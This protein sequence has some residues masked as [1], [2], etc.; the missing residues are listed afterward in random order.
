MVS[1]DIEGEDSGRIVSAARSATARP[2]SG[3]VRKRQ[4]PAQVL[5]VFTCAGENGAPVVIPPGDYCLS[6][7]DDVQ[8]EIADSSRVLAK[9][10][11]T[12]IRQLRRSGAL[13]I[14]GTFP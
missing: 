8:Y 11:F 10:W 5:A 2:V 3:A 12:Q 4:W 6:E 13:R 9:F 7:I 14:E 1:K